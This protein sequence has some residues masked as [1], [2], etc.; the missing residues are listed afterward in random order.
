MMVLLYERAAWN[1]DYMF[2]PAAGSGQVRQ[3]VA[4]RPTVTAIGAAG[5]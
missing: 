4:R 2:Q 5:L 1:D 3:K